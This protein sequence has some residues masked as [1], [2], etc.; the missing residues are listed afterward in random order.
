MKDSINIY[1]NHN[2]YKMRVLF[3]IHGQ[4][5]AHEE[6]VELEIKGISALISSYAT[7]QYGRTV[8][9]GKNFSAKLIHTIRNASRIRKILK[10]ECYDIL[11]LNTAFDRNAVI[12]DFIT[13]Y[14]LR[15]TKTEIFLKMHGSD[16]V[17]LEKSNFIEKKLIDK[18]LNKVGGIGLLS[19]QEKKEFINAGY[20]E[21]KLYVVKNP[22]DVNLYQKDVNFNSN[23]KL[24]E[25]TFIFIF[26]GRFIPQKGLMDVLEAFRKII[27]KNY[28]SHLFCIGDGPEMMKAKSFAANNKLTD[29]VTFTG[30]IPESEVRSYY[31]NADALV[32]PSHREGFPMAVFQSLASGASIIT[33]KTNAAADYLKE[34]ENVLW[35]EPK[36]PE[37]ISMAM[38]K[39]L[40]DK[41]LKSQMSINNK[42]LA[43]QFATENNALEYKAIFDKILKKK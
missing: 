11:F 2:N 9:S 12:R 20:S 21:E 36:N 30:F 28:P 14:M 39:I 25:N 3:G 22:V 23:N 24:N 40:T 43:L 37:K 41:T 15:R 8:D 4:M 5:Q 17:F 32:F 16:I 18:L 7:V 13:I 10:N 26:C 1:D 27:D 31:S 6:L 19:T 29:N 42:S 35:V 34:P 33:T 38:E